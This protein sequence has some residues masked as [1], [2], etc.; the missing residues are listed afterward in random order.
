MKFLIACSALLATTLAAPAPGGGKD[1]DQ[2]SDKTVCE[3]HQ[4]VVCQGNGNGGLI[5]LGNLLNGLLGENCSGGDVYCCSESDVR[6]TG[7]INLD[8]N[9][10]C[11][12]NHLL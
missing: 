9:L 5:S 7:L 8:L 11:S 12:L 4:T 10:Q 2:D 1:K 6:Q 3:S